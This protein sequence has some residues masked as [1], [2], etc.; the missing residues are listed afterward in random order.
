MPECFDAREHGGGTGSE[1]QLTDDGVIAFVGWSCRAA[2]LVW[3]RSS[4]PTT[5]RSRDRLW[6][7]H[8]SWLLFALGARLLSGEAGLGLGLAMKHDERWLAGAVLALVAAVAA[9]ILIFWAA[10]AFDDTTGRRFGA[11]L[12][13]SA[14]T[15]TACTTLIGFLLSRQAQRRLDQEHAEERERLR[16]EAAMKAGGLLAAVDDRLPTP[17]SAASGLLALTELDQPQLAVALLVDLWDTKDDARGSLVSTETAILVVDS[18]LRCDTPDAQLLAAELLCRN[19]TRLDP[20]QALHW[21]SSING[22]WNPAFGAK[23]KLLLVDGL[24]QM[25]TNPDREATENALQSIAVRLYGIWLAD[26]TPHV[27][28]CIGNLIAALQDALGRL[29]YS[30]LMQGSLTVTKE[31]VLEATKDAERNPNDLLAAIIE[32]RSA[33][34]KDWSIDAVGHRALGPGRLAPAVCPDAN[35]GPSSY[36]GRSLSEQPAAGFAVGPE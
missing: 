34:L 14:A 16:L 9:P 27:R 36:G 2:R 26:T 13:L 28:G 12:A 29:E 5:T 33:R 15:L 22:M 23:T 19:A 25:T 31:K 4:R 3:R 10:G 20:S 32:A 6:P 30:D 21:P 24:V 1:V 8:S 18:A 7:G 17:A 35:S 11:V